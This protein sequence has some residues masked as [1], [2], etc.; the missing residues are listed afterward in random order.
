MAFSQT[1]LTDVTANEDTNKEIL[2]MLDMDERHDVQY[3]VYEV[4][5]EGKKVFCCLSGGLIENNEIQFTAVGL[6][7]FEA[8]T[9][10][11]SDTEANYFAEQISI[12]SDDLAEQIEQVFAR[13]PNEARVCFVGDITGELKDELAKYFTLVH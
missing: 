1:L 6:A 7:A 2:S 5:Y 13:V 4:N 3:H 11:Q 10:I 9:N 8:M 12:D